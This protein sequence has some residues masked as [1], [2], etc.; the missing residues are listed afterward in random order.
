MTPARGVSVRLIRLLLRSSHMRLTNCSGLKGLTWW[1]WY[2]GD[3][4]K[5]KRQAN[6]ESIGGLI[7][8]FIV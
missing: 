2:K 7:T 8:S 3:Y 5:T 1:A 4:K 6:L